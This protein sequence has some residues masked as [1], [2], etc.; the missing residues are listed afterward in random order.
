VGLLLNLKNLRLTFAIRAGGAA[1]SEKATLNNALGVGPEHGS[2]LI[3]EDAPVHSR[4][5]TRITERIGFSTTSAHSY[6]DATR[7]LLTDSFDCITLD[8]D[9][10]LNDGAEMLQFLSGIC[11]RTP[12]LIISGSDGQICNEKVDFGR[13]L[14]LNMAEP[15]RKPIDIQA[16]RERLVHLVRRSQ[17]QKLPCSAN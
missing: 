15:I 17:S 4:L 8:L 3:I 13:S 1:V 9:L 11:C 12:I 7:L 2:I 10:G 16:V 6:S 5:I 14:G